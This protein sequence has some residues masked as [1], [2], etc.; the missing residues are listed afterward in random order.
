MNNDPGVYCA[1]HETAPP[2]APHRPTEATYHALQAAY[3]HFNW[4]LFGGILPCC[5]I[6]LQRRGRR[7]H[8]YY[9]PER[10]G[11]IDGIDRADEIALNPQHFL[12]QPMQET[13]STLV[14]EMCHLWQHHFGKPTRGAYHNR[15]WAEKMKEIGL[16]P[17][18]TG[19]KGSKE[20]GQQMDHYIVEDC[21]F[22]VAAEAL[23]SHGFRLAWGELAGRIDGGE[24]DESDQGGGEDK[25]SSNRL[26]Y[27]CPA[28][29][30]N[31]W[32]KPSLHLIC[33]ECE[34]VFQLGNLLRQ[35]ARR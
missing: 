26:K 33:G 32:G 27:T 12:H 11:E 2:K 20:V 10:F 30:V 3:D 35:A 18:S 17:S 13:L 7:T 24:D 25:N 28:C 1:M 5:L 6:T 14:H 21:P 16:H 4:E 23:A 31:V 29:D 9:S 15:E 22:D 8:G 19:K 34:V